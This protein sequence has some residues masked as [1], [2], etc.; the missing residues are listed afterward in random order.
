MKEI[1]LSK[2]IAF[3]GNEL[4]SI[5]PSRTISKGNYLIDKDANGFYHIYGKSGSHESTGIVVL[6]KGGY[7]RLQRELKENQII[8]N[9]DY[10]IENELVYRNDRI[11]IL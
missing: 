3:N 11:I 5:S 1:I 8:L 7:D 6:T 2:S 10:I 4:A 9:K